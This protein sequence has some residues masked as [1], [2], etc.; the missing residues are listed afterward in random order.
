MLVANGYAPDPRVHKE[1]Q[2]IVRNGYS[3]TV[4]CWDRERNRKHTEIIDGVL[5]RRFRYLIPR[6]IVSYAISGCLFLV[7]CFFILAKEALQ[8]GRVVV[9]CHDFNTLPVGW[10]LHSLSSRYKVVYDSHE[11]FSALLS[12]I[13]PR[14]VA[15]AAW[16]LEM[17][18]LVRVDA[19]ITVNDMI[20]QTLQPY[21]NAL[22]VAIYNTP[23]LQVS[24]LGSEALVLGV[25][26]E[27]GSGEFVLLYYGAMIRHRGLHAFLDAA[28]LARDS[29]LK[30]RFVLVGDGPLARTLRTEIQERGL[31]RT[32]MFYSHVPFER[33]MLM[34]KAADA[35]YIGF[36][37]E[38]PNNYFAS[39]NKLF[40]AMAMGTPVLAC[41]F[42]LL[43]R[44]VRELD[45]GVTVDSISGPSILNGI[46]ELLHEDVRVRCAKN[47]EY[48]FKSRYNWDI[49]EQRLSA[50]YKS[51]APIQTQSS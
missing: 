45:C 16:A 28:G 34:V 10:L 6:G 51:I 9:H 19:L 11:N 41:G 7:T 42:G 4:L 2:T 20:L 47:G 27:F 38:D 21:S 31:T 18:M 39:P 36:E 32:V 24:E 44:L 30:L 8:H 29:T 23:P 13:A 35:V 46:Q 14:V 40:E 15:A 12:T 1:A 5:V 33:A 50:I 3:V 25:R 17:L 49:M 37:P 48:W 26:N 22:G 43:G